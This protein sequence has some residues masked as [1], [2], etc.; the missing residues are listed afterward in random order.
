MPKTK[1][2]FDATKTDSKKL[3][4]AAYFAN[5]KL[6]DAIKVADELHVESTYP[7]ADN[8]VKLGRMLETV[9]GTE[10]DAKKKADADKAAKAAK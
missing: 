9:K 7:T 4:V 5:V 3:E 8:L 6:G 2:I 1:L 10:L